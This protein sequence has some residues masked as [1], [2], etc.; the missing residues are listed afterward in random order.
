MR[1]Y[2]TTSEL[3]S[4][5]GKQLLH[6]CIRITQDGKLDLQEIKSLRNW[7][8]TNKTNSSIAAIPYL[9]DILRRITAD[10]VIDRDELMELHLA[11]ERVIPAPNRQPAIQARAKLES[12]R[13]E[14]RREQQRLQKEQ[15]KA[16]KERA[17]QEEYDK[18]NRIRH[19]FEKVV[20]VTFPNDDGSERQAIIAKC[21]EG[22]PLFF[23]PDPDN[24]FSVSAVRVLRENG[25]QLGHAPEYLAEK[26]CDALED[27]RLVLG[28]IKN[29]TG[30][31]SDKPT[32][33]V[34]FIIYFL[35][36]NVTQ[37]E[38]NAYASGVFGSGK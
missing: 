6:I 32:R 13:R 31:T 5:A 35:S 30:G 16:E 36:K 18:A 38:L 26:I 20:G 29:L 7:L 33:G 8:L 24:Q 19:Q 11:V 17:R 22:E 14:R 21:S 28:M 1:V 10:G 25:E 2:L 4:E 23:R 12:G 34:N 27:D 15:E 3:A 37:S 9:L